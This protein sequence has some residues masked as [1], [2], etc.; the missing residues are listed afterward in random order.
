M[1]NL[2]T[3][4]TQVEIENPSMPAAGDEFQLEMVD[5]GAAYQ[6]ASDEP[7]GACFRCYCGSGCLCGCL[8]PSETAVT[9]S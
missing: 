8:S 3:V 9:Q 1:D 2:M 7:I 5:L 6:S 4:G